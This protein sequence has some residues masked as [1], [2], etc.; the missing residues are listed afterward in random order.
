MLSN[1]FQTDITN[2]RSD[3]IHG[4][5]HITLEVLKAI[6]NECI[7]TEPNIKLIKQMNEEIK[8]L[9]PEMASLQSVKQS[10]KEFKKNKPKSKREYLDRIDV[11]TQRIKIKENITSKNLTKILQKYNSIMT[12]SFSTT[13][14]NAFKFLPE[15]NRNKSIYVLESRAK[16]EGII[17]AKKLAEL[18]F[19]VKLIVDSA[20]SYYSKDADIIVIGADT[21]FADGSILNKVG[22]MQLALLAKYKQIP[23]Y[24]SASTNKISTIIPEDNA[25]YIREQDADEVYKSNLK[26]LVSKNIYFD[27]VPKKLITKIILDEDWKF[28]TK[29]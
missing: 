14:L 25:E 17:Q 28:F 9:H 21:I 11:L 2:I 18:G 26:N 20:A 15:D 24:V 5:V 7:R 6:R 3:A 10:L 12:I 16:R 23:F 19:Q 1:Q 8:T 13:I 4:A 29:K 27:I 22:S